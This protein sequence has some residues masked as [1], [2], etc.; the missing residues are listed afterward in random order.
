MKYATHNSLSGEK[1]ANL[2]TKLLASTSRCQSKT[3]AQQYEAGCRLFDIRLR[4]KGN[5]YIGAH[6]FAEYKYTL[7][8]WI[9]QVQAWNEQYPDDKVL[10]YIMHE[11]V[12]GDDQ[13]P[14]D[15]FADEVNDQLV[16]A[17]IEN[18][19]TCIMPKKTYHGKYIRI[20]LPG[21][22][23][24][25]TY[26]NEANKF[27][28]HVKNAPKTYGINSLYPEGGTHITGSIYIPDTKMFTDLAKKLIEEYQQDSEAFNMVNYL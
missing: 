27:I 15:K 24:I 21:Y 20:N 13:Y 14:F 16:A 26:S 7:K 19:C 8:D 4:K 25:L 22:A 10:F 3:V 28:E 1:P 6:G 9:K 23:P 11:D 5:E 18:Q 17:G 12:L 2:K